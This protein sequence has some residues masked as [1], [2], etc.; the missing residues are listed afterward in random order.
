MK[1]ANVRRALGTFVQ[2]IDNTASAEGLSPGEESALLK[3]LKSREFQQG[4]ASK[5]IERVTGRPV[6]TSNAGLDDFDQV[7]ESLNRR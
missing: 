5:A 7:E 3:L 4:V 6:D 2:I 1:L